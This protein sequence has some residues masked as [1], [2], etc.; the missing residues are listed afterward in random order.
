MVFL[1]HDIWGVEVQ[2]AFFNSQL[3]FFT[4]SFVDLRPWVLKPLGYSIEVLLRYLA[5]VREAGAPESPQVS[6]QSSWIRSWILNI[7]ILLSVFNKGTQ[8]NVVWRWVI[9][10]SLLQVL[11]KGWLIFGALIEMGWRAPGIWELDLIWRYLVII[12]KHYIMGWLILEG[13][14]TEHGSTAYS[15]VSLG[16]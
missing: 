5:G 3:I 10:W 4:W 12:L 16:V 9:G 2:L 14:V 6:S 8:R 7:I 1:L 13:I 15:P 11:L